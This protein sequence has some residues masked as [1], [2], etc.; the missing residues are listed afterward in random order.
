MMEQWNTWD[1]DHGDKDIFD[2]MMLVIKQVY[3]ELG[4]WIITDDENDTRCTINSFLKEKYVKEYM[5]AHNKPSGHLDKATIRQII[6]DMQ[7]DN[8]KPIFEN[9]KKTPSR[10]LKKMLKH[11]LG[12]KE[13]AKFYGLQKRAVLT[14]ENCRFFEFLIDTYDAVGD[15]NARFF[16][17]GEYHKLDDWY[18]DFMHRGI[19]GFANNKEIGFDTELITKVWNMRFSKPYRDIKV[20]V[21]ELN[22]A[23]TRFG[24]ASYSEDLLKFYILAKEELDSCIKRLIDIGNEIFR[25]SY[26]EGDAEI[27]QLINGF[28]E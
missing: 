21:D 25:N 1:N 28:S 15:D 10:H 8:Y 16:L 27:E 11:I 23:I 26:D 3:I 20:A 5:N 2:C 12:K 19:I 14:R 13:C 17:A 6:I 22:M 9:Y 7:V 24:D 4:S 18:V